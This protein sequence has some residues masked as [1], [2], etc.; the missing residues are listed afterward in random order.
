MSVLALAVAILASLYGTNLCQQQAPPPWTRLLLDRVCP[1]QSSA[2]K[3]TPTSRPDTTGSPE[4]TIEVFNSLVEAGAYLEAKSFLLPSANYPFG[5]ADNDFSAYWSA[6]QPKQIGP[7][8]PVPE[9]RDRFVAALCFKIT[10]ACQ[11]YEYRL[12]RQTTRN[13]TTWV[14]DQIV[15]LTRPMG[16]TPSH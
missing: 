11:N 8:S 7:A 13:T 9:S 10:G 1:S 4:H 2:P 6:L 12:L 15:P 16:G 3:S 14:I 5:W